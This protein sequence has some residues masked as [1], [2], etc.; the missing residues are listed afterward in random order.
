MRLCVQDKRSHGGING[1]EYLRG[2]SKEDDMVHSEK[3]G[4]A[5]MTVERMVNH[6]AQDDIFHDFKVR[7]RKGTWREWLDG[8]AVGRLSG[9]RDGGKTALQQVDE[10]LPDRPV[11][12]CD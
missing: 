10:G 7:Y 8:R 9:R 5:L 4:R 11:T 2:S 1:G 12:C 3:M 6:N